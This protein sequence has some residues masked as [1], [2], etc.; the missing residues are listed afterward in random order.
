M[1]AFK[2][3]GTHAPR[4]LSW[5]SLWNLVE[6]LINI[7]VNVLDGMAHHQAKGLNARGEAKNFTATNIVLDAIAHHCRK[8]PKQNQIQWKAA[9]GR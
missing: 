2:K 5:H 4:E 3:L 7:F 1:P 9:N 8:L 6:V